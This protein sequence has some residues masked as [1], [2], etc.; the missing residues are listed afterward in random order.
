[1]YDII[2]YTGDIEFAKKQALEHSQT[3]YVWLLHND[4]DY[5]DF[6]LRFVPNRFEQDQAHAWPS[7]NNE[8]AYTTWLMPRKFENVNY[9]RESLPTKDRPVS[10]MTWP[11]FNE[12]TL[13]G[14]DWHDSLCNWLLGL[15][16]LMA[17]WVW[18]CDQ[19]IDYTGFDFSWR[20]SY[21]DQQYIHCFTMKDR[22]QLSYTWLVNRS[23]LRDR[24]YKF[25]KKD[26]S[27]Q[28]NKHR[29]D[30]Y[31]DMGNITVP[32]IGSK[33]VRFTGRMEDVLRNAVKR[34]TKEWMFVYSSC[35]NY[36]DFD[37]SWLP[38]LDQMHYTHCWPAPGQ[39]KGD[40]FLIHIPSFRHSN[41][42]RW[43]FDH[44]VVKRYPWPG[45]IY[46][47]DN[48]ADAINDN[49]RPSSLYTVYYKDKSKIHFFPTPC[50]W[51][52]RPVVGMNLCNS[53]SLVPRDC[54]VEKEI[55]EYP[56]L[57]HNTAAADSCKMDIVFLHNNEAGHHANYDRLNHRSYDI[58]YVVKGV[59]PRLKAY[60][61]AAD[62]SNTDWF[63]AVFA[64]CWMTD[65]FVEFKWRPDYWQQAKHY[66]FYNHNKDLDLTYGHMA[67]IAYNKRLMLENTGGLDMTLAQQHA[68]VPEAISQTE[69][70]DPWDIWRTAFRETAK[71]LYYAKTSD[72]IELHYR[73]NRWLD[74]KQLWYNRGATD[75]KNYF[76]STDGEY[77]WLMLTNEWDWL[78]K[79]F[80][81]LYSAD[82]TV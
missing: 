72:N 62:K 40:T 76:E 21:F 50:L 73:L 10:H 69:L 47:Q 2:H 3:E 41:E 63:L 80:D 44:P 52:E 74:A 55:Y 64:K 15:P 12:V 68:V 13:S 17:D 60:Q 42:F 19:R 30:V 66:I 82:F 38:D 79:R 22:E 57:E 16:H 59:T 29:E 9:H 65:N 11:D 4:V 28:D 78:R 36:E 67:P 48:L 56:Y 51:D 43:N 77:A 35:S 39:I 24:Q 81:V 5:T 71:L 8:Q 46:E 34:C 1:M 37:F 25:I 58:P 33:R 23:V 26:L 20:P 31:L 6:D 7:H 14:R 53:V 32:I 49:E 27:F 54:I 18:V 70:T 45:L 75:A 61:T